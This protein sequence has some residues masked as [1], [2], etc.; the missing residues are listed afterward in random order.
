[1]SPA[2]SPRVLLQ[3]KFLFQKATQ[4]PLGQR[5]WE[6]AS[7]LEAHPWATPCP[8]QVHIDRALCPHTPGMDLGSSPALPAQGGGWGC[9]Q[10]P[11]RKREQRQ[12]PGTCRCSPDDPHP[13]CGAA[14]ASAALG[15]SESAPSSESGPVG[16]PERSLC[17]HRDR[18]PAA[19]LS[20][21]LTSLDRDVSPLS[22]V[23]LMLSGADVVPSPS[24]GSPVVPIQ[25]AMG[26]T[27]LSSSVQ[28]CHTGLGP[29]QLCMRA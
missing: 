21:L 26:L 8:H 20:V 13:P 2:R 7:T 14:R 28:L 10:G 4:V 12:Q 9:R 29:E 22:H 27:S 15:C 3:R 16:H 1:M 5:W 19:A 24:P 6:W 18:A 23:P 11:D 25:L 17:C